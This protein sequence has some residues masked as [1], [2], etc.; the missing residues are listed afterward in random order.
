[1]SSHFISISFQGGQRETIKGMMM[2]MM[3]SMEWQAGGGI[4]LG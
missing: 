4:G 3:M 2:M 1:M